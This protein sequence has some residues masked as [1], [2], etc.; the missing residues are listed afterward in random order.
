MQNVNNRF[1][2]KQ[3]TDPIS[4]ET[5]NKSDIFKEKLIK[6]R[7]N[8]LFSVLDNDGNNIM[9]KFIEALK[10]KTAKQLNRNNGKFSSDL[11]LH[12]PWN[13]CRTLQLTVHGT[14]MVSKG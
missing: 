5:K 11:S 3:I 9:Q 12:N 7:D 10:T 2:Q 1:N 8:Y 6:I 13:F 4:G 14:E